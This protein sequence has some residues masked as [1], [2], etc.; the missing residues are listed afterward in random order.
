MFSSKRHRSG[1]ALIIGIFLMLAI[2]TMSI[3]LL[4]KIIPGTESIK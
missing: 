3:Y 4:E 1:V 2:S